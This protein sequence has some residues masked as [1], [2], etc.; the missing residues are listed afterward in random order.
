VADRNIDR[1]SND[2]TND[3]S[4]RARV[5][6]TCMVILQCVEMGEYSAQIA[7]RLNKP[8]QF[9]DYHIRKLARDGCLERLSQ[10]GKRSYPVFYKLTEKGASLLQAMSNE[11][12]RGRYR[13]HHFALSYRIVRDNPAFLALSAGARLKGGVIETSGKVDGFTVRRFYSPSG[14]Q[15]LYLYSQPKR[16]DHPWQLLAL[17]AIELDRLAQEISRRNGMELSFERI[18]QK[19]E[20]EDDSSSFARFW[21]QNYGCNVRTQ[22]GSIDA[23]EGEWAKELTVEDAVADI[24]I[25]RNVADISEKLHN[26]LASVLERLDVLQN[27]AATSQ[28]RIEKLTDAVIMNTTAAEAVMKSIDRLV[29]DAQDRQRRRR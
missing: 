29:Q 23:S 14:R 20:F 13:F 6:F 11:K 7:R 19:A 10:D 17:S 12:R 24:R 18:L 22:N 16:G 21:G 1:L 26:G 4:N 9:V 5:F 2:M 28:Q 15:W 27:G 3:M 8:R 25:G